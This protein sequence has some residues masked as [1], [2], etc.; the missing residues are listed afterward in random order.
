MVMGKDLLT[1]LNLMR[2]QSKK[3]RLIEDKLVNSLVTGNP[4]ITQN[5]LHTLLEARDTS[6][7][8]YKI[9]NIHRAI[10]PKR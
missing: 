10:R 8:L 7:P 1:T 5:E 6:E 2:I 3:S 9:L 4:D